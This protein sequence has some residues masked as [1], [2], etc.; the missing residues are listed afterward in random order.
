MTDIIT[1]GLLAAVR[2]RLTSANTALDVLAGPVAGNLP[3]II[4]PSP[5]YPTYG[6]AALNFAPAANPTDIAAI[7][8]NFYG[9][10]IA[11]LAVVIQGHCT[12]GGMIDVLIQRSAEGGGGTSAQQITHRYDRRNYI[13]TAGFYTYSANRTS[14]GNGIDNTRTPGP[15]GK[16]YLGKTDGTIQ[17][18]PL[19]FTFSGGDRIKLRDLSEWLVINL[20]GATMPAGLA[21]DIYVIWQEE[22]QVPTQFAGDSTTSN[23]T[24]I[25][26]ELGNASHLTAQANINNSG[27]NGATL[28]NVL[29][30]TSAPVYPLV[31]A[32]GILPRLGGIPSVMP[33]SYGLND[34]RQGLKTRNELISMIDAAIHATLN[35]TQA[36][37]TYTS[38][39]GANTEFT[40]PATVIAN[41]DCQIILWAPNSLTTDG[42][43]SSFVTLTGRW[44]GMTLADAAQA[45]TDDLYHAYEAFR[46]DPRIFAL[47][48]KQDITGRVCTTIADSGIHAKEAGY[49]KVALPLMTDI[50]HPNARCQTLLARQIAPVLRNAVAAALDRV[51]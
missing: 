5:H 45:I 33:F 7:R 25:F 31:A 12:D 44:S 48:H 47:V 17:G 2:Q 41:P 32:N 4:D 24:T 29:L 3:Q 11:P 36:G 43:G 22:A 28:E 14:G 46:D 51:L 18:A 19:V 39:M 23:A 1:A 9:R 10:V 6:S 35:G 8:P 21:L 37:A 38:T 40:W 50:L 16:L 15:I 34:L 30:N 13:A 26:N 42:N 20:N 49:Q 27:S